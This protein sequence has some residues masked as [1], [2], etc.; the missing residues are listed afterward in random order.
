MQPAKITDT[1]GKCY[2]NSSAEMTQIDTLKASR[3]R[4]NFPLAA[5]TKTKRKTIQTHAFSR[6]ISSQ[7]LS[8]L[9]ILVEVPDV[10]KNS[11]E[12]T[13]IPPPSTI[14]SNLRV[15]SVIRIKTQQFTRRKIIFM[16]ARPSSL[17][18]YAFQMDDIKRHCT[19]DKV[20]VNYLF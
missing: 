17:L 1:S 5:K 6:Q 14:S 7:T 19:E 16:I 9:A 20:E 2:V 3:P 8:L 12:D 13:F 18:K 10:E 15:F 4:H 11:Q